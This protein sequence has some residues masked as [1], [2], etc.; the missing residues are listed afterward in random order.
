[1]KTPIL[2]TLLLTV[3]LVSCDSQGDA[4]PNQSDSAN[5]VSGVDYDFWVSIEDAQEMAY[6]EGKHIVL[7][8][9]AEWCGFCRRMNE[10]TYGDERVQEA[11]NSYYY[12]VRIDAESNSEI[13]FLGETYTKSE[14]AM[15]F[16]VGSYPTTVF[17]SPTGEPIAVQPGFIDPREFHRML[18][19][20][21]TE[22]YETESYQEFSAA[23]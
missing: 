18:T 10:E 11:L 4:A 12:P 15:Q 21:G 14:L 2:L 16:G 8:I 13:T 20:V 3:L 6:D 22:R 7:D 1:M 23:N 19:Y 5:Q 17:L 9:Y